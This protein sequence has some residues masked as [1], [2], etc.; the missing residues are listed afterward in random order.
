[1]P[2]LGEPHQPD[3]RRTASAASANLTAQRLQWRGVSHHQRVGE[4]IGRDV[5]PTEQPCDRLA[6]VRRM[7]GVA[8]AR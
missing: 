8:S 4:H 2:A 3:P 7:L 5:Q 1:M 6:L